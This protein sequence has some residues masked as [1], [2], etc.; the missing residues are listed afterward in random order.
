MA[1]A[2]TPQAHTPRITRL[3]QAR[4]LAEHHRENDPDTTHIYFIEDEQDREVRMLE[5]SK[6]VESYGVMPVRFAARPDQNLDYPTVVVL[7]SP[8]E[9]K[10]VQEENLDLPE[11][12]GAHP[13]LIELK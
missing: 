6:S 11:A 13:K 4:F 7:L 3:E 8:E 12:W 10:E 9:M 1:T 5:V 2:R